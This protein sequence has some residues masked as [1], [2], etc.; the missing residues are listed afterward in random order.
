MGSLE[1]LIREN[2]ARIHSV[3]DKERMDW[4]DSQSRRGL[5]WILT[6]SAEESV[7]QRVDRA[8][9]RLKQKEG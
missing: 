8:M 5:P 2:A 6:G 7:R 3:T 4:L 9:Q 1:E